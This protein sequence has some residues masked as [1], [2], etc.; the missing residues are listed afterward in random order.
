MKPLAVASP[1]ISEYSSLNVESQLLQLAFILYFKNKKLRSCL[2]YLFF[3]VVYLCLLNCAVYYQLLAELAWLVVHVLRE[4]RP[5]CEVN[6]KQ[7]DR[8]PSKVKLKLNTMQRVSGETRFNHF[9]S[10]CDCVLLSCPRFEGQFEAVVVQ[11]DCRHGTISLHR[12]VCPVALIIIY[13]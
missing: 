6:Q 4:P 2:F 12:D 9:K 10:A 5:R 13:M 3:V 11:G 8:E 7:R 1:F